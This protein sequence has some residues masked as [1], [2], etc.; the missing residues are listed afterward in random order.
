MEISDT[1]AR[2]GIPNGRR[3]EVC[4]KPQTYRSPTAPQ[5]ERSVM[6]QIETNT[7]ASDRDGI[8]RAANV[9][10]AGGLVGFPT[11]TVYGLGA[12]A[13]N[14]RAV[15]AI[16]AAKGR[17]SFNPLIVHVADLNVAEALCDF[18]P[19]ALALAQAF[20]P[21]ALTLVLPLRADSGIAPL[22]TAGLDTLAVRVPDHPIAQAL[23]RDFDGPIAAPSANLSGRISPTVA[24]H[25]IAGLNGRIDAVVDGGAC[26]VGVESTI[27]GCD[28]TPT[29]LRAGG[30][31]R[32]AIAACLGGVLIDGPVGG[33]LTAPGQM[34]SHYAPQG[35]VRLN[36]TN[37]E[38]G[39]VLLGFGH[40]DAAL[41]L[42]PS[43]DLVEA[44]TN[45]F[46]MLHQLDAMG[47]VRI[48][49]SPVPDH[50]LGAAIN[51]RLR[52]AAAPR[53]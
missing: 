31:P 22:V 42:S 15:A 27:V 52:R 41:N 39:E 29:L 35:S 25:V 23:L 44:A 28:G 18:S 11:E 1:W 16:F 5:L 10:R 36:A 32:E 33:T 21:G 6:T 51:D 43:S 13:R 3:Y 26:G 8:A 9:L 38:Q 48:A 2:L 30:V 12:D 49:V 24:A 50:G 37:V 45:L 40:V 14:D 17:P 19:E 46:A 34:V 7:L 53:D 20:W 4:N 47:A